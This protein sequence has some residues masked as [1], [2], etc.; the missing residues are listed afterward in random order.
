[1]VDKERN[2][3]NFQSMQIFWFDVDFSPPKTISGGAQFPQ[4]PS[5]SIVFDETFPTTVL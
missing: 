4:I 2:F 3:L 1:M 5:T